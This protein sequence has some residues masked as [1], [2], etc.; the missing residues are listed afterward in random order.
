MYIR[1]AV[2]LCVSSILIPG[3]AVASGH[4]EVVLSRAIVLQQEHQFDRSIA[5]L[6]EASKQHPGN[7][8]ILYYLSK[9]YLL[10]S[11][12][13]RALHSIGQVIA[14][15]PSDARA[16]FLEGIILYRLK[17]YDAAVSVLSKSSSI[18]RSMLGPSKYWTGIVLEAAGDYAGA[19]A[20]YAQSIGASPASNEAM[21]SQERLTA[22]SHAIAEHLYYSSSVSTGV[23]YDSNVVDQPSTLPSRKSDERWVIGADAGLDYRPRALSVKMGLDLDAGIN[24]RLHD[25]D[26]KSVLFSVEPY[27]DIG[28]FR[29]AIK[30]RTSYMLF[31]RYPYIAE[32][33]VI[34]SVTLHT[35]GD[36]GFRVYAKLDHLDFLDQAEQQTYGRSTEPL[37]DRTLGADI[38]E[39]FAQGYIRAGYG[40]EDYDARGQYADMWD[41]TAQYGAISGEIGI[42]KSFFLDIGIDYGD[43][44]YTDQPV[45][46][47][48]HD[49]IASA[50][51]GIF[52][53]FV[54]SW[55][56]S[57]SDLYTANSSNQSDYAYNR[58]IVSLLLTKEF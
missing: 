3:G 35:P 33:D 14:L 56:A 11:M 44:S 49:R 20:A 16:Y 5:L 38:T 42:A 24:T 29:I 37:G 53:R 55:F 34:P 57:I 17:S 32:E 39:N 23:Q 15:R 45:S 30:G 28:R 2:L 18:D 51:V 7:P 8:D 54:D 41:D 21:L 43:T 22:L 52:Y 36:M 50:D 1:C 9:A 10:D 12:P 6:E 26:T 46:P 19:R 27:R 48:R 4:T 31:G 25:F 58:N 40:Y 47:K 13:L